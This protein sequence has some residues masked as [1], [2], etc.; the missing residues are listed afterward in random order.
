MVSTFIEGPRLLEV[1]GHSQY[2]SG[3]KSGMGSLQSC[4][5]WLPRLLPKSVPEGEVG[6]WNNAVSK[7]SSQGAGMDVVSVCGRGS[8]VWS[9]WPVSAFGVDLPAAHQT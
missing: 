6:F 7:A 1:S 3:A 8:Q 9:P 2:T 4:F 5:P